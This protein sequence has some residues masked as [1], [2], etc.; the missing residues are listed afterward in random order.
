MQGNITK[1][2]LGVVVPVLSVV[3]AIGGLSTQVNKLLALCPKVG[4]HGSMPL[5]PVGA[6][7]KGN[8]LVKSAR[9]VCWESME[10]ANECNNGQ[11]RTEETPKC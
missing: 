4:L 10:S 11:T 8:H 1:C 6:S 9:H 5:L 3:V 2:S 7:E